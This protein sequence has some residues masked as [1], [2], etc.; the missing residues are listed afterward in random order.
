MIAGLSFSA[1]FLILAVAGIGLA[2]EL[3]F[4]LKSRRDR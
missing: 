2:I 3:P 1:W 4:Y